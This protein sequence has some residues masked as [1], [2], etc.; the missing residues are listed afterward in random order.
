LG[1]KAKNPTYD[2]TRITILNPDDGEFEVTFTNPSNLEPWESSTRIK[3]NSNAGQMKASIR[4][5]WEKTCKS[6]IDVTLEM[7]DASG[8][9][10]TKRKESVKNVYEIKT[11]K[12]INGASIKKMYVAQATTNAN[13]Q[14]EYPA[15]TGR[16]S[17]KPITGQF[18]IKCVDKEGMISYSE[19]IKWD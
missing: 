12:F 4:K 19:V 1:Y 16:L 13:M 14:I 8:A 18:R 9:A 2:T 6:A 17:T 10:T 15:D 7:F 3:A 5:Y 11:L